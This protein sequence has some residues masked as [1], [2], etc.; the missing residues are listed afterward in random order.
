VTFA[1]V[2]VLLHAGAA[3]VLVGATTHHAMI[4][5]GYLRGAFKVRLARIYAATVAVTWL[6]TFGLGL[7]AYPT[8]RCEVRALYLDQHEAWASNLFDIKEHTAALG[9]PL[10]IGAFLLSRV[11]DPKQDRALA[12]AYAAMVIFVAAIVWFDLF[13]GLLITMVKGV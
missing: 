11:L 1:R 9:I 12:R 4:A 10:V 2:L 6:L 5:V 7:L 13:S 8:F 3:I